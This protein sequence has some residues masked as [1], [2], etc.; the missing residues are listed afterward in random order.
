VGSVQ[1]KPIGERVAE[2]KA[3]GVSKEVALQ[4]LRAEGYTEQEMNP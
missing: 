2:L 4:T 1:R 3:S